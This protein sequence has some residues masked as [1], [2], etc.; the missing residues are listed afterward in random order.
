MSKLNTIPKE[1]ILVSG[2]DTMSES[3]EEFERLNC[4]ISN[5]SDKL[6]LDINHVRDYLS[7]LKS[8]IEAGFD[9]DD[10]CDGL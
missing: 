2:I 7:K 5:L 3:V 9:V 8:V 6:Y 4:Y 10:L 1:S